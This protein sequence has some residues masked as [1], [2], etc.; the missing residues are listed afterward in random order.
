VSYIYRFPLIS[1]EPFWAFVL[2]ICGQS[3]H[4]KFSFKNPLY[5]LDS[6]VSLYLNLFNW[7]NALMKRISVAV[8][9]V[10]SEE[11]V[12]GKFT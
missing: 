5:T 12:R 2:L 9:S 7:S 8:F 11:K 6:T 3:T 10:C 4:R 1:Q